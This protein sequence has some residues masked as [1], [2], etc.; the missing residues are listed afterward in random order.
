MHESIRRNSQN[1]ITTKPKKYH[2]L[3]CSSTY[4]DG[5]E[6]SIQ[7]NAYINNIPVAI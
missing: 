3:N 7:K 4:L 5:V 6:S 2:H 1:Q